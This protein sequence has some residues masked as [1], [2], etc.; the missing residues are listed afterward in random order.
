MVALKCLASGSNDELFKEFG[1]EAK[2][3]TF[4]AE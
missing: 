3:V 1:I 2:K 4:E